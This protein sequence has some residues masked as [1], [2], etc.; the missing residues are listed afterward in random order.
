MSVLFSDIHSGPYVSPAGSGRGWEQTGKSGCC[1]R[2]TVCRAIAGAVVGT[3]SEMVVLPTQRLGLEPG[4]E[5]KKKTQ[6]HLRGPGMDS[7]CQ[8]PCVSPGLGGGEP[9]PAPGSWAEPPNAGWTPEGTTGRDG[10]PGGG[11]GMGTSSEARTSQ[12]SHMA[13]S[14]QSREARTRGPMSRPNS[15]RNPK[16]ELTAFHFENPIF[17]ASL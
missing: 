10:I 6:K 16:A 3:E 11:Y 7:S 4:G 15:E 14:T 2:P 9:R 12:H 5:K 13:S 1:R 17:H 8:G